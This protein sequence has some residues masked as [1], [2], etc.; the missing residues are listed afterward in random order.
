MIIEHRIKIGNSKDEISS[1]RP[2]IGNTKSDIIEQR[3]KARKVNRQ[4]HIH[5]PRNMVE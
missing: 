3:P 2:N 1:H 4:E 5:H